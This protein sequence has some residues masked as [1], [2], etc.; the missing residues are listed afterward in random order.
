MVLI[1][2]VNSEIGA[3]VRRNWLF[4]LFNAFY[5]IES[6]HKSD[7]FSPK[8]PIFLYACATHSEK[9]SYI[10]TMFPLHPGFRIR[11][12]T[13]VRQGEKYAIL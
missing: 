2:D 10:R 1:L 8:R 6:S 4:G 9:P 12:L 13:E 5:K 3:H 7:N 11:N